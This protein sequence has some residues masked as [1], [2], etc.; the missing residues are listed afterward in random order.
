MSLYDETTTLRISSGYTIRTLVKRDGHP[1]R[2]L[3]VH[4]NPGCL[5]DW[6]SMLEP[7]SAIADIAAVDLPGFG[8]TERKT[9]Y[10]GN[11]QG[12][13]RAGTYNSK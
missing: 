1:R 6:H 4:G 8:K 9:Y 5:T 13:K 10:C 3:L 7:L 2:C 12:M 11:C